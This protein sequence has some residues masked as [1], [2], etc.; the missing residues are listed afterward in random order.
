MSTNR[1]LFFKYKKQAIPDR[2]IYFALEECNGFSSLLLTQ[3]FDAEIKDEKRFVS[4]MERYQNGEMIEYI[5][6]KAYFLKEPFYV[7]KNVLIPRQETE[8][9]VLK[10]IELIKKEYG[11]SN[12]TIVDLCTGSGIIG[13]S[14]AKEFPLSQVILTDISSEALEVAKTNIEQHRLNNIEVLQGDMLE[15]LSK[16]GVKADVI[17]CNPPYIE[18]VD[19]IDKK[20]WEQEPHLALL[21]SPSTYF[22]E[23]VLKDLFKISKDK[24]LLCFEIGEDMEEDLTKLITKYVPQCQSYFTNDIYEKRRFLFIVSKNE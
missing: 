14:L 20:T 24:Y 3:S 18:K 19:T 7:N 1:E 13:I 10:S 2:V 8:Q 6:E 4:A 12:I 11:N 17:I 23:K 9:L 15:P 21:A 5:F 22:Y 16:K